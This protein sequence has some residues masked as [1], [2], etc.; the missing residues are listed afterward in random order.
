[1]PFH[2]LLSGSAKMRSRICIEYN[3]RPVTREKVCEGYDCFCL[4]VGSTQVGPHK[5]G[6]VING[7]MDVFEYI[8]ELGEGSDEVDSKQLYGRTNTYFSKGL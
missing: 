7:N 8:G 4:I 2:K 5:P 6:E 3:R 1:M